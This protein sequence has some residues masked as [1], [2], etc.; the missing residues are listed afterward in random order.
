M[1][2]T[3]SLSIPLK[4]ND[5]GWHGKGVSLYFGQTSGSGRPVTQEY[6]KRTHERL[7][8]TGL[9]DNK[10]EIKCDKNSLVPAT[11]GFI[12]DEAN[13]STDRRCTLKGS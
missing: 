9:Y 1:Y 5:S 2:S 3:T 12:I 7:P 13:P 4:D 8:C 10:G 6:V 11:V